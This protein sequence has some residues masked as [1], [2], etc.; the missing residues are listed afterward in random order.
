MKSENM[1]FLLK[2]A[3]FLTFLL[4]L[5]VG[6]WGIIFFFNVFSFIAGDFISPFFFSVGNF[7][8]SEQEEQEEQKNLEDQTN[9]KTYKFFGVSVG[10]LFL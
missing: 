6:L 3:F 9:N 8:D 10:F 4:F 2:I 7:V 1:K 5:F